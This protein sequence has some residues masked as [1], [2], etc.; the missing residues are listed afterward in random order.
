MREQSLRARENFDSSIF[1]FCGSRERGFAYPA[2]TGV[3]MKFHHRCDGVTMASRP[4]R[5][6]LLVSLPF[7]I[8]SRRR[9]SAEVFAKYRVLVSLC[10]KLGQR[11][12]WVE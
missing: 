3:P 10:V 12:Q 4:R 1:E 2:H 7:F 5:D 8:E 9:G 6:Y 11:I